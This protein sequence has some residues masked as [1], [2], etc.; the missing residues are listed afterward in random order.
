M[1]AWFSAIRFT[2]KNSAFIHSF[3]K[4]LL[5]NYYVPGTQLHFDPVSPKIQF[6]KIK[7]ACCFFHT[8]SKN[9]S[10]FFI[11]TLKDVGCVTKKVCT[12]YETRK[13]DKY[14]GW[15]KQN[16]KSSWQ[17]GWGIESKMIDQW[18]HV[19]WILHMVLGQAIDPLLRSSDTWL[20]I[21]ICNWRPRLI[22]IGS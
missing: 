9:F 21:H 2:S 14:I 12:W 10:I 4:Y 6:K 17:L 8:K 1:N 11:N 3:N 20:S 16:L 18:G 5:S 7:L 13:D 15:K 19:L 22:G